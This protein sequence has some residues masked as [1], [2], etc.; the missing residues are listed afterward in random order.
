MPLGGEGKRTE[1]IVKH[2]AYSRGWIALAEPALSCAARV[3]PG[4]AVESQAGAE[5]VNR[6]QSLWG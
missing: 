5:R 2:Q 4:K 3:C 1:M 6:D